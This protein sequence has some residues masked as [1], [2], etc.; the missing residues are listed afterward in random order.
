MDQ[1]KYFSIAGFGTAEGDNGLSK[2]NREKPNASRHTSRNS[3]IA[4]N[5]HPS[6]GYPIPGS[7]TS[8]FRIGAVHTSGLSK[9]AIW[10]SSE[11]L[12]SAKH[13][14]TP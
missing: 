5:Y 1:I 2:R 11:P 9:I 8:S 10:S 13:H 3:S 12:D 4:D 6:I 7:N 14:Q